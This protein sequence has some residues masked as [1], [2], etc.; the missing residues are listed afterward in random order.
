[1][2]AAALVAELWAAP[3]AV[4]RGYARPDA[5]TL[6]LKETPMRGGLVHLPVFGAGGQT[7]EHMAR[8]A[9]HGKPLIT[10]ASSFLPP[11]V[12]RIHGLSQQRPV[13][14]ELLDV[15]ESAPASY[16]VLDYSQMTL[17]EIDAVKPLVR[18]ALG[19]GRLRFCGRFDDRGLKDLFAVVRVEPEAREAGAYTPPRVR[20]KVDQ[21]AGGDEV[22]GLS[23][24]PEFAEGGT[25]LF[26]LYKVSYGRAPTYA[27][28]R[29][30]LPILAGSVGFEFAGWQ[31]R[32]AEGAGRFAELWV[33]REEF[34]R[35]YG[36]MDD[37]QYVAAITANAGE[38]V[39]DRAGREQLAAALAAK[40]ETRAGALL[41]VVADEEFARRESD[42]AFVTMHYFSFLERDPDPHGF[43]GWMKALASVD[44]DSFTRSFTASIEYQNKRN[45]PR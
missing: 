35:R 36:L 24:T 20:L 9:D 27:E 32:L 11:L 29:R 1:V 5:L 3:L 40:E 44:R 22:V 28:F 19:A 43:A 4:V 7:F 21:A 34:A 42:A 33:A 13:P 37:R 12:T 14:P 31:Q 17:E 23:L 8:A 10:A 38:G 26:R 25:L 41:R 16:L 18:H 39:L 6:K 2:L 45:A 30:D 15:L